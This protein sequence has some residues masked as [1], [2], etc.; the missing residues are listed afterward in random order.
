MTMI[1]SAS[2]SFLVGAIILSAAPAMSYEL[3]GARWNT[4]AEVEGGDELWGP[5]IRID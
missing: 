2:L 4:I 5:G 3:T 1:R